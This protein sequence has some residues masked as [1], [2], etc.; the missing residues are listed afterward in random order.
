MVKYLFWTFVLFVLF[1]LMQ[2]AFGM[3][4]DYIVFGIWSMVSSILI[5]IA[6]LLALVVMTM[7]CIKE[8]KD[9]LENIACRIKAFVDGL[10]PFIKKLLGII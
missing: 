2:I 5:F 7:H 10:P 9:K 3:Y 1:C 8:L 4:C 6:L